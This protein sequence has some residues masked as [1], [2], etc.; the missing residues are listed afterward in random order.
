M[1]FKFDGSAEEALRQIHDKNY[2]LPF[3]NDSRK[4]YL[5]GINFSRSTRNIERWVVE[6][7]E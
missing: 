6:R 4:L 3:V 2:A 1:E 5:I 7:S